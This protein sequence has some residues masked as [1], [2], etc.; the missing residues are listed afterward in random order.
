M[1]VAEGSF[2]QTWASRA[3]LKRSCRTRKAQDYTSNSVCSVG[4]TGKNSSFSTIRRELEAVQRVKEEHTLVI[5][6][7]QRKEE[8]VETALYLQQTCL[9]RRE[10]EA[11]VR[12]EEELAKSA[13]ARRLASKGPEPYFPSLIV[14]PA[15]LNIEPLPAIQPQPGSSAPT[16]E[17]VPVTPRH[18]TKSSNSSK[19][20]SHKHSRKETPGK[21][22]R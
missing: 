17:T 22:P 8:G 15:T 16:P 13:A 2:P 4:Q 21:T 20:S 11:L 9:L 7:A 5:L 12:R 18:S 1:R 19:S 6:V 3:I 14:Q 10:K